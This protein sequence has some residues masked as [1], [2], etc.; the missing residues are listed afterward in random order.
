MK[1]WRQVA[2]LVLI[3]ALSATSR[4]QQDAEPTPGVIRINV[5]LVQVDAVVTNSDGKAVTNLKADDFEILQDQKPQKIRNFEFVRVKDPLA[6]LVVRP[7]TVAPS[8]EGVAPPPA[9]AARA[10]AVRRTIA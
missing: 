6:S 7:G 1:F 10:E 3:C 8:A 4:A 9:P 2:A 5:N